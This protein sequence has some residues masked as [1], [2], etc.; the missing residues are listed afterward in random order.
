MVDA[1]CGAL[2]WTQILIRELQANNKDFRYRGI[3]IAPSVVNSNR[4]RFRRS[5]PIWEF[6]CGDLACIRIPTGFDVIFTRDCLQ[7]LPYHTIWKIIENVARSPARY[8]L[9]GSYDGA[10]NRNISPGDYFPINIRAG[11][12]NLANPI[13]VLDERTADGKMLLLYDIQTTLRPLFTN[14]CAVAS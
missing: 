7:H 9:V 4:V 6:E 14:A 10:R 11:P 12:F 1:P 5:E 2:K 8:W 3:D 13:E